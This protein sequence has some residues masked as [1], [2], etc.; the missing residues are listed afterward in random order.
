MAL[1][2]I[3]EAARLTK[4]ARST[5][6]R[7][8]KEGKLSKVIGDDGKPAVETSELRR[9]YGNLSQQDTTKTP[10]II[11]PATPIETSEI[12]DLEKE[13]V[14]LRSERDTLIEDR[15]RWVAQAERLSLLLTQDTSI[16]TK[17]R[18]QRVGWFD[19]LLGR[20]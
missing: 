6:H 20:G 2:N 12:R 1:H 17:G 16:S 19:R 8:I 10:F 13:L 18:G 15:D 11:Q 9:V 14:A 3:S 7:H 5:I 4:K